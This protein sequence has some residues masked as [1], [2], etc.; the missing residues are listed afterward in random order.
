MMHFIFLTEDQSSGKMLEILLG[1]LLPEEITHQIHPYKGCGTIPKGLKAD[2]DPAKRNL[3]NLLPKLL[4]GFGKTYK[5][6]DVVVFVVC[7][8]DQRNE[9]DFL[10]SLNGVLNCCMHKPDA[11]FCLAVE[12]SEAWLLGDLSAVKKAYPKAKMGVLKKYRNDSICGTWELLADAI[13][14]GGCRKL[15]EAGYREIGRC[16]SEWAEKIT[17]HLEPLKNRSPSFKNFFRLINDKIREKGC[18]C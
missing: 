8:L 9:K 13:Y 12:E 4:E 15:K 10:G 5:T 11:Y 17:P 16:K 14:K 6:E 1:K 3:L 2:S 7:D 18:A